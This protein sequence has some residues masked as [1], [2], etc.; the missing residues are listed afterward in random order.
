VERPRLNETSMD[1]DMYKE[2][3]ESKAH[4]RSYSRMLKWDWELDTVPEEPEKRQGLIL[5]KY[6]GASNLSPIEE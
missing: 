3:E 2:E 6:A 4:D 1:P 5:S